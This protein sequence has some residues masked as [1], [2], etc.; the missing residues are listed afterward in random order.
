LG[1]R[2]RM[3]I[4]TRE[5]YAVS[6]LS[7]INEPIRHR[8]SRPWPPGADS[9]PEYQR[10]TQRTTW[11][12]EITK[13][14]TPRAPKCPRGDEI[15]EWAWV[16]LNYRPHAYQRTRSGPDFRYA[17]AKPLSDRAT[18][19]ESSPGCRDLPQ[20][21]DTTTDTTAHHVPSRS[22][23]TNVPGLPPHVQPS[24]HP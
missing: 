15:A 21:T 19:W 7:V 4:E 20:P 16:E 14:T 12:Y 3:S 18:C 13:M 8:C 2:P 23:P 9:K 10:T 5:L 1:R 17:A 6:G 24:V 22:V 11:R